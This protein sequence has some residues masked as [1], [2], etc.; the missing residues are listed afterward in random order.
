M[1]WKSWFSLRFCAQLGEYEISSLSRTSFIFKISSQDFSSRFFVEARTLVRSDPIRHELR[2]LIF[3]AFW[4]LSRGILHFDI[5]MSGF[6][7]FRIRKAFLRK[8]GVLDEYQRWGIVGGEQGQ[9]FGVAAVLVGSSGKNC[10]F[11]TLKVCNA[12]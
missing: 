10:P 7:Q 4:S 3:I 9:V 11:K 5:D 2:T 8:N 6:H 1:I 12:S